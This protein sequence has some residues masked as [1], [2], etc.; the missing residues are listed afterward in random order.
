MSMTSTL[1]LY[2]ALAVVFVLPSLLIRRKQKQHLDRLK[3]LQES[4]MIG[5][6][7]I[8]TAGI[9]AVIKGIAENTVD[10]EI[11]PNILVTFE[12]SAVISI[13][14]NKTDSELDA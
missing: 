1:L 12:K 2:V 10:L 4:M 13:E 5:Q 7:V 9:H 11:A 3:S 8:T 14:D 6:R